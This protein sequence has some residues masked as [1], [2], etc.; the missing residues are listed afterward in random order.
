MTDIVD[1]STRSRMMAGI[2]GRNTKPEV[3]LRSA[4]HRRGLRF[5]LHVSALPGKPDMVLP[6]FKALVFVHG[7]FWHRHTGCRLAYNPRSKIEFW[8]NKFAGTVDRDARQVEALSRAGWR[9]ATVWECA[10]RD[11]GAEEVAQEVDSWLRSAN[12]MLEIGSSP[13]TKFEVPRAKNQ[14]RPSFS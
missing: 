9:I 8:S 3:A 10:L 1:P 12:S 14:R 6:R 13:S 2:K 4:L 7:C 11:R 5:R